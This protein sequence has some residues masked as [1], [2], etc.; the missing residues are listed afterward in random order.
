MKKLLSV[1]LVAVMACT[2][3]V[4][5]FAEDDPGIINGTDILRGTAVIDGYMDEG[6]LKSAAYELPADTV[7]GYTW[8]ITRDTDATATVRFMW[9]DHYLYIHATGIDSTPNE[10]QFTEEP[11]GATWQD[12]CVIMALTYSE[13][14]HGGK[15]NCFHLGSTPEHVYAWE[16]VRAQSSHGGPIVASHLTATGWE[17]EMAFQLAVYPETKEVPAP[18]C[19]EAGQTFTL[20]LFQVVDCYDNM[21]LDGYERSSAYVAANPVVFTLVDKPAI[22]PETEAETEPETEA[23]TVEEKV[24]TPAAD[25]PQTFDAGIIA[26]V[27]A[28]VSAAGYAIS[29]KR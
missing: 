16:H 21:A 9:D 11:G 4:T 14:S 25:A 1:L 15:R 5:A 10:V 8:G 27:A 7:P 29:K 3:A 28:I 17:A 23:E 22:A 12:D 18:W 2:M 20:S 24:D 26:A 19:A 13:E 6:Y